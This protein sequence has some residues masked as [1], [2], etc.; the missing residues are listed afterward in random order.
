M[1]ALRASCVAL[2]LMSSL[3][4]AGNDPKPKP[5]QQQLQ[6]AGDLV[7]KAIAKSQAGDHVLAIELYQQ[8]YN[9]IPQPILLSNIGPEYQQ[10]QQP[11]EAIKYIC[12]DIES[13][14]TG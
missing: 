5:T 4:V 3:A 14:P 12:K 1:G 10:A 2:L 8:A 9:I 6:Q 11:V 7:K 13:D